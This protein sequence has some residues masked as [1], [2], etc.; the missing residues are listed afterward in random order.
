M[1]PEVD[2]IVAA[3]PNEYGAK[4]ALEDL[5]TAPRTA[6]F[7]STMRPRCARTTRISFT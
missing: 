2:V 4:D 1:N 5:E 6:S 7:A 3:Y